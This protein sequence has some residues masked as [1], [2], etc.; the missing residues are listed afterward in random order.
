MTGKIALLKRGGGCTF[1]RKVGN[2]QSAG[3]VGVIVVD[4]LGVCPTYDGL[5]P[6]TS[7]CHSGAP[8]CSGCPV[9]EYLPTVCQCTLRYMADDGNGGNVQIPSFI[10]TSEWASGGVVACL[11]VL[12]A[13]C[14][15]PVGGPATTR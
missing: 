15:P 5:F 11:A 8:G 4:N 6:G 9:A 14:M 13:R 7:Q 1:T 12:D 10:V 3:A 2:A